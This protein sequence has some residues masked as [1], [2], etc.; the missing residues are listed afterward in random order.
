MLFVVLENTG[1]GSSSK[2][3]VLKLKFVKVRSYILKIKLKIL[4][5]PMIMIKCMH[6]IRDNTNS[7]IYIH[8]NSKCV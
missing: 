3:I 2:Y 1:F 4:L 6:I 7:Q 8:L 5:R